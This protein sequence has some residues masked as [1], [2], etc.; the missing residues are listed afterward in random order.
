V[1][2]GVKEVN[3]DDRGDGSEEDETSVGSDLLKDTHGICKGASGS[4]GVL[5]LSHLEIHAFLPFAAP[6]AAANRDRSVAPS[7][8]QAQVPAIL[9]IPKVI[10]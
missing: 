9:Y 5:S 7:T 3:Y 4:L 2:Q 10:R 1:Q 8:A 6:L